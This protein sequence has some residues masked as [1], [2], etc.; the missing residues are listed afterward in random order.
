M[1]LGSLDGNVPEVQSAIHAR[2]VCAAIRLNS[3][4]GM[5]N[6][7]QRSRCSE[8]E[9]RGAQERPRNWSPKLPR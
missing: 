4:S 5:R 6:M 9:L 7:Q 3:Q 1:T 8:L 2:P